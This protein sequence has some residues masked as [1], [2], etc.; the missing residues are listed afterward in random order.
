MPPD[1]TRLAFYRQFGDVAG[2]ATDIMVLD[3]AGTGLTR[4]TARPLS[5][6][7]WSAAWTP[8]GSG[9]SSRRTSGPR[10]PPVVR[11]HARRRSP[12][13]RRGGPRPRS[14]DGLVAFQPP[15]SRRILFAGQIDSR[16][17]LFVMN[18][19]GTDLTTLIEPYLAQWPQNSGGYW[20]IAAGCEGSPQSDLVPRR[21]IKRHPAIRGHGG[22]APDAPVHD[23]MRMADIHPITTPAGDSLDGD[24]VWSPDGSRI[25]FVRYLLDRRASGPTPSFDWPMARSRRLVRP[26]PTGSTTT[27]G[28]RGCRPSRGRPTVRASS[29]SN[30]PA[31]SG[32]PP[33]P[34]G[35]RLRDI[36]VACRDAAVLGIAGAE[37]FRSR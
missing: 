24:P 37:R 33:R 29:P 23:R 5:E 1:G 30:V 26:S 13:D 12:G 20:N 9:S 28:P 10:P 32:L 27:T 7:P 19:D 15:D 18:S 8:D 36:A 25:A 2:A 22:L 14:S 35:R 34:G 31:P 11:C 4:L 21:P 6:I 3:A 17:G 16:I